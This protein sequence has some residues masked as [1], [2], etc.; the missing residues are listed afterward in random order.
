MENTNFKEVVEFCEKRELY[1]GLGK[2]Y[3][4]ILIIGKEIGYGLEP[5]EAQKPNPKNIEKRSDELEKE[6]WEEWSCITSNS[7]LF[8]SKLIEHVDKRQKIFENKEKKKKYRR[9]PTWVSYQKVVNLIRKP[10]NELKID[11]KQSADFFL[12][13][14]F[15][16]EYSQISLPR[17]NYLG[18]D[19]EI[20]KKSI[21][22]RISLF[23]KN[24]FKS[25]PIVIMACG[26]YLQEFPMNLKDVFDVEQ[27][28]GTVKL[29]KGNY[30]NVYKNG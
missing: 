5:K 16:T 7:E 15:I 28:G 1:L 10:E 27:E 6:N 22:E 3:K 4:K 25:F 26:S 14:C 20:K 24:F 23:G 21:N 17:S 30:Y 12:N 13:H 19:N 9:M 11:K 18:K 29:S 8:S 2:P